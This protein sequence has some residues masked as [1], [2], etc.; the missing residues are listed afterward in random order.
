M[1]VV[2]NRAGGEVKHAAANPTLELLERLGYVVR[3]TLYVV[4]GFLALKIALA[5]LRKQR[6]F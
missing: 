5:R 3:G 1:A 2:Q 6:T 4:M